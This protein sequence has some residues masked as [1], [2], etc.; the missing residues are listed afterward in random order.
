LTVALPSKKEPAA[1]GDTNQIRDLHPKICPA[2]STSPSSHCPCNL[3][4]NLH[5][6]FVLQLITTKRTIKKKIDTTER[7]GVESSQLAQKPKCTKLQ[8]P[9]K[10]RFI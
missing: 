4:Q 1:A 7:R 5:N 3:N 8:E 10:K 2:S 9:K 6:F